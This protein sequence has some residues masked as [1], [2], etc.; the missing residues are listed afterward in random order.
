MFHA[1][2][3]NGATPACSSVPCLF[4][5]SV[6]LQ[7]ENVLLYCAYLPQALAVTWGQTFHPSS[8]SGNA[9]MRINYQ[10]LEYL[11]VLS[12]IIILLSFIVTNRRYG[13]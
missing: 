10:V 12:F 4:V 1:V 9:A 6:F 8:H 5:T 2:Q 11:T 7:A 13:W 3:M